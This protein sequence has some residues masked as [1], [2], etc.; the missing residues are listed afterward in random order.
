V[1][2]LLVGADLR[3]PELGKAFDIGNED[4]LSLYLSGHVP[5]WPKVHE[6]EIPNLFVAAAGPVPPNPAALLHSK[7]LTAFLKAAASGY[8]IVIVDAPPLLPVADARILGMSADGVVLV[9]RANR[10]GKDLIR[11]AWKQLDGAG[12][13]VLGM[14]LNGWEPVGAELSTYT[15][16]NTPSS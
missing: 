9:V 16:Y 2:T 8:G 1:K 5:H 12:A 6:T 13:N 7:R 4:G 3:R 15:Y 10:T 11:R 14:V